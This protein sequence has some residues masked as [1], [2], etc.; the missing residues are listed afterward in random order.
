MFPNGTIPILDS[1]AFREIFQSMSEGIIIVDDAGKIVAANPVSEQIFGYG[2]D[3]LNGAHLESLLPHRYRGRHTTFRESFNQHPEPRRMGFGR[4][5]QALRKDGSEFPV[6]ISLSFTKVKGQLLVMAFISDISERKKAEEALK[7]SEEQL[8]V[9]AAELEKKVEA[10]TQALNNT[11]IKL[12]EEVRERKRAE[13]DVRKAFEKERELN[14]LKSKF[15]SI[16]SHEFRTPLSAVLSSASLISQYKDKGEIEKVTKHVARIKSSV[17]HLTSILN[18]FLSLGKLE[19]GRIEINMESVSLT[20]FL[21]EVREELVETLK[22]GQDIEIKCN[23]KVEFQT[24]A[25]I[26][27]NILFNLI[28]NASKYSDAGKKIFVNCSLQNDRITFHVKDEGI[29]IPEDDFKHMF[30]RFF[31]A[32]NAGNTQG[33]G[34]G[35]N[36]VK[37][38][39]DL[40]GGSVTFNS[41]YGEGSTFSIALPLNKSL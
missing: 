37:R 27:R 11:I 14:E 21:T 29:G 15:V 19:E 6:E 24:D 31:R 4:D 13:E 38:Y 3:E 25:R 16:A 32:S 20:D 39:A 22:P 2:K 36:I 26:L 7:R 30:D 1:D 40:L 35:L 34:L 5:L 18:D 33:T 8:L 12:E 28:S 41:R 17:T 9:Y 10:R 23:T